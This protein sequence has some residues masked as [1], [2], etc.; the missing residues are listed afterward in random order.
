MQFFF[1]ELIFQSN[2]TPPKKKYIYKAVGNGMYLVFW[3]FFFCFFAPSLFQKES[4]LISMTFSM[5]VL[6]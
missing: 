5:K 6:K 2:M 1:S 4:Q 3:V